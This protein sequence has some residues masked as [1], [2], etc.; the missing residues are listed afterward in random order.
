MYVEYR[1][2]QNRIQAFYSW[3]YSS[4]GRERINNEN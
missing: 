2:K 3:I 4:E 1:G